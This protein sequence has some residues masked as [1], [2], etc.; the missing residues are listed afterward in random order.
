MGAPHRQDVNGSVPG[1]LYSQ[2]PD[3]PAWGVSEGRVGKLVPKAAVPLSNA[4]LQL[5]RQHTE[6][7]GTGVSVQR[8][9]RRVLDQF[10]WMHDTG[11]G[12]PTILVDVVQPGCR[13]QR[14]RDFG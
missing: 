7:V 12:N 3:L 11:L 1:Q 6:Q 13:V 8:T 9:D 2:P 10:L 5:C 4:G 14:P